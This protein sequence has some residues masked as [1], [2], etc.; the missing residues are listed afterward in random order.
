MEFI[1]IKIYTYYRLT[2]ISCYKWFEN[3]FVQLSVIVHQFE[4]VTF[5]IVLNE[6]PTEAFIH[7]LYSVTDDTFQD[8]VNQSLYY[9]YIIATK[10]S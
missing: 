2:N 9:Y 1:F 8:S 3:R 7:I 10:L 5:F 4:F 6:M